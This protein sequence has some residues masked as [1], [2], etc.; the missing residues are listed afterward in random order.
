MENIEDFSNPDDDSEKDQDE[1]DSSSNP[2]SAKNL[3]EL[4]SKPAKVGEQSEDI[5]TA[6]EIPK[7][8]EELDKTPELDTEAPLEH[9]SRVEELAISQTLAEER[10]QEVQVEAEGEVDNE[11]IAAIN[12]LEAVA[13][14]GY[15]EEEYESAAEE[16]G[17]TKEEA[18]RSVESVPLPVPM[19][20]VER[21]VSEAE[22]KPYW[23]AKPV[24]TKKA[25]SK[26]VQT[27]ETAGIVYYLMGRRKAR[28]KNEASRPKVENDLTLEVNDLRQRLQTR[29][30]L[31]RQ[32]AQTQ[33]KESPSRPIE[34]ELNTPD[35]LKKTESKHELD[36]V[37][38]QETM[39]PVQAEIRAQT[40][41][42]EELLSIARK[43]EIEGTKLSAIYDNNLLGEHGLRRVVAEYLKGG[44][45][46][47]VLRQEMIEREIDFERDPILR[48]M[49]DRSA[50]TAKPTTLDH[51]LQ[52]SGID[53]N[54]EPHQ[55]LTPNKTKSQSPLG[56]PRNLHSSRKQK[57]I[58]LDILM[59]LLILGL[60]VTLVIVIFKR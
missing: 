36:K 38:P 33:S 48:D 50:I 12:Y 54:E 31:V 34:R 45:V 46:K 7:T 21:S 14:T 49:G 44:N 9:L 28:V 59:V 26:E 5:F 22:A 27:K 57:S 6:P 16:L 8:T 39:E 56:L 60:I 30:A 24:E 40:I 19:P 3:L 11:H 1:K 43:I 2:L 25:E 13:A 15:I 17:A 4:F 41:N 52:K 37:K 10:L 51:L 58:A 32:L 47:K 42:R 20:S 35:M 29:E 18:V 23:P 55:V 53:W